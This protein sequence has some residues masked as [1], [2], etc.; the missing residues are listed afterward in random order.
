MKRR[1]GKSSGTGG[2]RR[3]EWRGRPAIR[4]S[5]GL[6]ELTGLNGGG[7]IAE[8]RFARDAAGPQANV[9][10]ESPWEGAAPGTLRARRLAGK[11]GPKGVGEF[12]ASYTGHSLCLDY[13]GMPSADE[14][15]EGLPLHGEAASRNWRVTHRTANSAAART[16]WRI[17]LPSAG[18]A[19]ERE[20][21]L[22]KGES[23]AVFRESV[24]NQRDADHY[25]HWVQHVTLGAPLLDPE[26]SRV[27]ISGSRAKTWPLGYEGKS[28][29]SADRE[30]C[31][32]NAPREKGGTADL[33]IPFGERGTGL[34]AFVQLDVERDVQFVAALNWRLGLVSGYLFR[35][36]D[37]PWVTVWEENCAREY[38]P[39]KGTT[40]A[41]GMEFGTTPMPIGKEAT[42]LAGKLFETPGWKR[43]RSGGA[44]KVV[45]AAFLAEVPKSW[46]GVQNI[47][48]E[49]NAL[50][51]TGSREGE[52]I[53][54]GARGIFELK[55]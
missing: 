3:V 50:V 48:V 28:L 55:R 18:L 52:K 16:T 13:F 27:F 24:M 26:C 41:R 51:M 33:S 42:F 2:A 22:S 37:F 36:E 6:I 4:L 21:E 19:F 12:L 32:P 34:V 45:Y 35:R 39:W 9:L 25:F 31:W 29:V 30:F 20:I 49:K 7:H 10:W 5:N 43:I 15:R 1:M 47:Q 38:E 44:Q 14:V 40:Q 23:V 54:I 8:L 46:R 53:T 11:Y 17:N